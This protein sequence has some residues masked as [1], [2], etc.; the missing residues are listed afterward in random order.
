MDVTSVKLI[1]RN[2]QKLVKDVSKI[3]SHSPL[4]HHA[5]GTKMPEPSMHSAHSS[6]APPFSAGLNTSFPT[7]SHPPPSA[8]SSSGTGGGQS[9]Y[10]TSGLATPLSVAIGPAAAHTV[11]SNA[12]ANVPI[13]EY[14]GE[15]LTATRPV[16]ERN[17]TVM[18]PPPNRQGRRGV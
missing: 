12:N 11:A 8:T 17:D 13:R 18:Q 4:Y 14:L 15:P 10:V 2:V 7:S 16:H 5:L 6:L 3:I 9:P 1:M